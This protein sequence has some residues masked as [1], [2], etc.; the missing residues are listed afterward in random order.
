VTEVRPS[1]NALQQ[2]LFVRHRHY[3]SNS[4]GVFAILET[5]APHTQL[6]DSMQL[7]FDFKVQPISRATWY[8]HKD[9]LGS[10]L[11]VTDPHARVA[12]NFWYDPWG[13]RRSRIAD[14][15]PAAFSENQSTA[16]RLNQQ[17]LVRLQEANGVMRPPSTPAGIGTSWDRGF[18]GQ[19][20]LSG[21]ELIH[22]NSRVYDPNIGQFLSADSFS[23]DTVR[24][25]LLGRYRYAADNPLR[26]VDPTGLWDW[27][28]AIVGAVVGFATGGPGGAIAGAV[29]GGQDD[30]RKFVQ[31]NWKQAAIVGVAVGVTVATGG[32]GGSL[33]LAILAGAAGGAAGGATAAALYGG[34][35][36][37]VLGAAVKGA[38]IGGFSAGVGY[39]IGS[40]GLQGVTRIQ[41]ADSR[42]ARCPRSP[43]AISARDFGSGSR[44]AW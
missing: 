23:D 3:L 9:Q 18:T 42:L 35:L 7:S 34:N 29:I 17:E 41:R 19:E 16:D 32:A 10:V 30:T 4:A 33:A 28:G 27:G 36:D 40:A 31:E 5:N 1:S 14:Q 26:Y 24:P 13:N 11:V 21:F 20:H 44:R 39:G 8:I 37:D 25:D 15:P 38:V 12:A 2:E 6:V 22:M 43:G